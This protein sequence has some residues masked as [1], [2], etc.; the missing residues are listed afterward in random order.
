M[1]IHTRENCV[2][3]G[4]SATCTVAGVKDCYT[5]SCGKAFEDAACNIKITDLDAW[6]A[7]GG[8]GYIAPTGHSFT[9]Y[10][11]NNDATCTADGTK[12]AICTNGCGATDTVADT[13]SAKGHTYGEWTT[14]KEPTETETGIKE[15]TC[16]ACGD[17]DTDP[18]V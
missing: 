13:G 3:N 18:S 14:T 8:N 7:V 16:S 17:K 2:Q 4:T 1:A 11:S 5:C 12:T 6:K 9:T 10:T 15:R